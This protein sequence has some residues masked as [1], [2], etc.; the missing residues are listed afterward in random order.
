[1][2]LCRRTYMRYIFLA[3][4]TLTLIAL[5]LNLPDDRRSSSS[6]SKSD[7]FSI[8]NGLYKLSS[9]FS[10]KNQSVACQD[11][12]DL[13]LSDV[14]TIDGYGQLNFKPTS[15]FY[16]NADEHFEK[17]YQQGRKNW[18]KLP[19]KV[20]LHISCHLDFVI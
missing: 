10:Y 3:A 17:Q 1:M 11:G 9:V 7:S 15:Q 13:T 12:L 16:W 4:V 8:I 19:L 20:C 2:R 14:N 5:F 6:S 18:S